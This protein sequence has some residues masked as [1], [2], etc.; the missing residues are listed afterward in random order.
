MSE[1]NKR[2]RRRARTGVILVAREIGIGWTVSL[3]ERRCRLEE[4]HIALL[5][6]RTLLRV[7]AL[8]VFRD[9]THQPAYAVL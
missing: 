5:V 3:D 2:A 4:C 6:K 1:G 7:D 8:E 9:T